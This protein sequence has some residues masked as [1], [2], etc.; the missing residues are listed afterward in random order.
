MG[1]GA[2][3]P[4]FPAP[5][6]TGDLHAPHGLLSSGTILPGAE[7]AGGNRAGR[8]AG[9]GNSLLGRGPEGEGDPREGW[10]WRR[11]A[12]PALAR[13]PG[14]RGL[15]PGVSPRC[16]QG[17]GR[18]GP[19]PGSPRSAPS[20]GWVKRRGNGRRDRGARPR[21]AAGR[22][23]GVALP[24]ASPAP[25]PRPQP[26]PPYLHG[27]AE[28][29]ARVGRQLL[30][31]EIHDVH[32]GRRRRRD[33]A[34]GWA[35]GEAG[36]AAAATAGLGRRA[37][38]GRTWE[39]AG[40]GA[41]PAQLSFPGGGGEAEGVAS[42]TRERARPPGRPAWRV[43]EQPPPGRRSRPSGKTPA[44]A[45]RSR[46]VEPAPSRAAEDNRPRGR[47]LGGGFRG[48]SV[49]WRAAEDSPPGGVA[50]VHWSG[51]TATPSGR[52]RTHRRVESL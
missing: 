34:A 42:P 27:P 48:N 32:A 40:G 5:T 7:R 47:G 17:G 11:G 20:G 49:P 6:G 39:V 50:L 44:P 36:G 1:Q 25:P 24:S 22:V 33:R 28:E 18:S 9:K 23:V 19:R 26:S 52:P 41:S 16:V 29:G 8:G 30:H 21:P 38:A 35:S 15:Q 51:G 3:N 13:P 46:S 14:H 31:V 10:G 2:P 43:A 45:P 37:T 12:Q 4:R